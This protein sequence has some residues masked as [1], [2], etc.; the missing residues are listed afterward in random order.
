MYS[1]DIKQSII[2]LMYEG[3]DI[4]EIANSFLERY[5]YT[6]PLLMDDVEEIRALIPSIESKIAD[7]SY[8]IMILDQETERAVDEAI[9]WECD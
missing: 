1:S 6:A 9:D 2:T 5:D 3:N 4:Y 8:A 7:L